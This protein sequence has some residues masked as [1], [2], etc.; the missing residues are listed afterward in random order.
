MKKNNKLNHAFSLIELSIVILIVGILIAGVTSASRL[1]NKMSLTSIQNQTRS[2]PVASIKDLVVWYETSLD[3]SF[4]DSERSEG[5]KISSWNDI[6]PQSSYKIPSFQTNDTYKPL[7]KEN[8]MNGLATLYFDGWDDHLFS[9][10]VGMMRNGLSIFWVA[11]RNGIVNRENGTGM[12]GS[13]TGMSDTGSEDAYNIGSSQFFFENNQGFYQTIGAFSGGY[14]TAQVNQASPYVGTP[15]IASVFFNGA[16]CKLYMNNTLGTPYNVN[17]QFNINRLFLGSR[18][19][20]GSP[21]LF[22]WG[23]YA[24]LIIFNRGLNDEE[25]NAIMSYLSKKYAIKISP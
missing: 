2:S 22:F 7:Y 11:K 5:S 17:V 19:I 25:R 4:I 9:N 23:N 6:N 15:F 18:Y 3:E 12:S 13:L 14:Y 1:V 16:T 10:G 8:T 21:M 24:E 20:R